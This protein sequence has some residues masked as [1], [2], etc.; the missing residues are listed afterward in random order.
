VSDPAH[1]IALGEDLRRDLE[2]ADALEEIAVVYDPVPELLEAYAFEG[3]VGVIAVVSG[4]ADERV[5]ALEA[6][7]LEVL[8]PELPEAE[9]RARLQ[10]A[11]AR[12]RSRLH[13]ERARDS[14]N[15]QADESE[16]DLRLAAR[17]QRS[18]LPRA[19][20]ELEGV[21]FTTAYLPPDF[22]SGDTYEVALLAPGVVGLYTLDAV[23]HGVR[24]ALL[25][26]LL[27]SAFRPL[28]GEVVRPPHEV[29]EEVNRTLLQ[30]NL[31]D[32]P[33]AAFCYG[34]LDVEARTLRLANAG[35]PLPLR[36]RR[37]A[38][39]ERLGGS[40]L[41]LGIDPQPYETA[42]VALEPGDRVVFFTDGADTNYDDS[43]AEQLVLHTNLG[44]ED[45]VAG[46]LGGV[47]ELDAEGRPEDD[48]TSV[49]FELRSE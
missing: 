40:G 35:H 32:S 42:E 41:L 38:A 21:A 31:V 24:A 22:V 49:A 37:G 20:P 29:L 34:L 12:F 30:A 48:V 16:R 36:L 33:T 18:F 44:L 26:T 10:T 2:E 3:K 45:Q 17:L 7:A 8:D 28:E 47:I 15:A 27:R 13:L 39:P 43:F 25:T 6:G 9:A 4:G 46:A 11:V 14:L 19:L 1:G 5:A 23:G